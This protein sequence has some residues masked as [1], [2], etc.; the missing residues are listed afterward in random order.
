MIYKA[1]VWVGFWMAILAIVMILPTLH[2]MNEQRR[3]RDELDASLRSLNEKEAELG[4]KVKSSLNELDCAIEETRISHIMGCI[5]NIPDPVLVRQKEGKSLS[6]TYLRML[7]KES[8][9]FENLVGRMYDDYKAGRNKRIE[10]EMPYIHLI[11]V[12]ILTSLTK[13]QIV[14]RDADL[15]LDF[16]EVIRVAGLQFDYICANSLDI[17]SVKGSINVVNQKFRKLI[18]HLEN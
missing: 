18:T 13:S 5:S 14:F 1:T 4:R 15:N 16:Y 3:A 7:Y 2:Q 17:E 12:E 11:L 6:K 10:E 9:R 8:V